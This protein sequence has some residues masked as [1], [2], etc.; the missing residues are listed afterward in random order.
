MPAS[1]FEDTQN[2]HII[3]CNIGAL[4]R[5]RIVNFS[6]FAM[7]SAGPIMFLMSIKTSPMGLFFSDNL[8][9][10]FLEFLLMLRCEH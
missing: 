3:W 9:V 8:M 4:L 7:L 6:V 1:F 10:E 2:I 5:K